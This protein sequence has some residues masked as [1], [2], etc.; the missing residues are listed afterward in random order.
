MNQLV[1][2]LPP[3]DQTQSPQPAEQWLLNE[4]QFPSFV[5]P[6]QGQLPSFLLE[7]AAQPKLTNPALALQPELPKRELSKQ[8]IED[9]VRAAMK[10]SQPA[11]SHLSD[12]DFSR[13]QTMIRQE[14]HLTPVNPL[15]YVS[16]GIG[17]TGF[18]IAIWSAVRA[19]S[20]RKQDFDSRRNDREE[21]LF[22]REY[23]VV[24]E[25]KQ[26]IMQEVPSPD[27]GADPIIEVD[28]PRLEIMSFNPDGDIGQYT[29]EIAKRAAARCSAS[30]HFLMEH[31]HDV[32][33]P[34]MSWFFDSAAERDKRHMLASLTVDADQ[35]RER[36]LVRFKRELKIIVEKAFSEG[37]ID[38]LEGKMRRRQTLFV[39][40]LS[41]VTLDG[42]WTMKFLVV[43]EF[44]VGRLRDPRFKERAIADNPEKRR[45]I[46]MIAEADVREQEYQAQRTD[47]VLEAPA[48]RAG[49]SRHSQPRRDGRYMIAVGGWLRPKNGK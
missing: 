8:E 4:L 49:H 42:G 45:E 37:A 9:I 13:I 17:V 12:E 24:Q 21:L 33:I 43:S 7:P 19:S 26:I 35:I 36:A 20:K 6:S 28:D 14:V 48:H 47:S 15:T 25:P 32:R 5:V 41:D 22:G 38:A 18:G 34:R 1:G 31:F 40:P 29:L 16:L 44:D 10:S 39:V 30:D 46:E 23:G 11:T 27:A 3:K 2:P